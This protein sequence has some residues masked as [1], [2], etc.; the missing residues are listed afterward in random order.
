[1]I[2][3]LINREINK[4][5][6]LNLL[7]ISDFSTPFQTPMFYTMFRDLEGF[8]TDVFAVE[9]NMS[10]TALAVVTIQKEKGIKGFF[11]RRA[12]IYGGPLLIENENGEIALSTLLNA[13]KRNIRQKVIY[14]ETRNLYDYSY[15]KDCFKDCEWNYEPYLNF[16][17]DCSNEA[18]VWKNFDNNRKRQ[19]KKAIEQGVKIE[20]AQDLNEVAVFHNILH[21]LY[22]SK[23]KKPLLPYDFFRIF[24]EKKMG[25]YLLVKFKGKIIGGIMCP[26]LEGKAIYELYI[27]GLDHEYKEASP[28]VMATYAAVEYGLKNGLQRFDF[29][30]AGKPNEEY[31][32][33]EFKAKFGGEMI[34]YGRFIKICNPLL[35]SIGKLGLKVLFKLK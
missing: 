9:E 15:Y 14:F 3:L 7:E 21:G 34:E 29:M 33:R 16:H 5:K 20:E 17:L 31:G 30:G 24:F 18:T 27:C 2:K 32:V 1:L 26:I 8:S 23:V 6:W 10:Y 12:I 35:Y 11:S 25:K 4:E 28:S 19:I 22:R 13:I